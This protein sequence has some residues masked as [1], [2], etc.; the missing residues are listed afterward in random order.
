[1]REDFVLREV[2]GDNIIIPVGKNVMELNGLMV[3]NEVGVSLWKMLQ[4]DITKEMLIDGVLQEYDV[5]RTRA[6]EDIECFL[7]KLLRFGILVD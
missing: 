5:E 1:M 2:A 6:E 4:N 7:Q 3:V